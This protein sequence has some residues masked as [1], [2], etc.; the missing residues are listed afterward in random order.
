[1]IN[2]YKQTNIYFILFEFILF[3]F[4]MGTIVQTSLKIIYYI[5]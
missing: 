1:M 2:F 4:S 5:S 3:I